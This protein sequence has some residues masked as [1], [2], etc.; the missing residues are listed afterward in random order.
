MLARFLTFMAFLLS[1][2]AT[3]AQ[4]KAPGL[5]TDALNRTLSFALY[6]QLSDTKSEQIELPVTS[7][8]QQIFPDAK[9]FYNARL[10]S[11]GDTLV[12][13]VPGFGAQNDSGLA[14]YL[15]EL[16]HQN[17]FSILI[18]DSPVSRRFI[19]TSSTYGIP[20]IASE[21]AKD[22]ITA[23]ET[24]IAHIEKKRGSS[25]QRIHVVGTS[26]GGFNVSQMFLQ[27]K[28]KDAR[29]NQFVAIS[30][31]IRNTYSLGVI[32]EMVDLYLKTGGHISGE[33]KSAV[34]TLIHAAKSLRLGTFKYEETKAEVL[35][36][37]QNKSVSESQARYLIGRTFYIALGG[38]RS[39][40]WSRLMNDDKLAIPSSLKSM[41]SFHQLFEQI[42][43]G[44][45]REKFGSYARPLLA[46]E[47]T[48]ELSFGQIEPLKIQWQDGKIAQCSSKVDLAKKLVEKTSIFENES[49]LA[50]GRFHIMTW[51]DD[52]LLANEDIDWLQKTAVDTYLYDIGGHL[53]GVYQ[54]QFQQDLLQILK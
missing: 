53:G 13:L 42:S 51:K 31:P 16:L 5:A 33:K 18:L 54:P 6:N 52:M 37:I 27:L 47:F 44:C 49:I 20:G 48:Q 29:Y 25:F 35:D 2:V 21:D 36:F 22:L 32:N 14:R 30:P 12:V 38:I 34:G 11:F 8:L 17:G 19:T 23:A 50:G 4:A 3:L 43:F 41:Q 45:T 9:Y 39:G 7:R 40:Y 46:E 10:S 26:L 28:E 24:G 1:A 15:M